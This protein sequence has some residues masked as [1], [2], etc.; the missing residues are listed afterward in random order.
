MLETSPVRGDSMNA[1]TV[2]TR[3]AGAILAAAMLPSY[4]A[5]PPRK[6]SP[7]ALLIER[8]TLAY[9]EGVKLFRP[10]FVAV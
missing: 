3:R 7:T 6:K 10:R 9:A 8:A 4:A 5:P 1:T 2:T